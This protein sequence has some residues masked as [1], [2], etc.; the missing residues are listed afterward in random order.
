[1]DEKKPLR[2][3]YKILRDSLCEKTE[4]YSR[5][6][7]ERCADI[8]GFKRADAVLL[9]FAKGSEVD[10][11]ALAELA[12]DMGKCVAYPRCS[13]KGEMTFHKISSL[14][15]L[16]EGSFG[17]MEPLE[18]SPLC[19]CDNGRTVCF[20][21]ALAYDKEGFR[22]GWGGGYYDRFLADFQGCKIGVTYAA[23]VADKLPRGE[24]D[25]K[26]DYIVT[27]SQVKRTIES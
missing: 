8:D 7:C 24:Y 23:C 18:G 12:L 4:D 25:I 15:E 14:D 27:E 19:D 13:G 17:I 21:P 1:M 16:K 6:I 20:V 9:Y 10:L 3:K 26:T 5:I 22:L 2:K 11:S